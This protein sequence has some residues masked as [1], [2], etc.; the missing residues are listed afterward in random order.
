LRA[1]GMDCFSIFGPATFCELNTALKSV[2]KQ[3]QVDS[4]D[5]YDNNRLKAMLKFNFKSVEIKEVS[6]KESFTSLKELLKK[7]KY[8]G[9]RGNGLDKKVYFSRG[10]LAE[11]EEAYLNRFPEICVTYQVFFCQGEKQ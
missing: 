10:L 9:I 6:Y 2:L 7:I 8:S 3:S 4:A 1:G 11:L 5:F